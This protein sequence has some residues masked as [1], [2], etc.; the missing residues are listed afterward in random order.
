MVK[1]TGVLISNLGTPESPEPKDVASYLSEFLM[2]PYVIQTPGWIRFFLVRGLIVPF[3]KKASSEKYKKIWTEKGSP[4][5][6]ETK[7]F[8]KALQ[9]ALGEK[10]LVRFAMRYGQPGFSRAKDELKDCE[11]VIYFPQYPQYAQSTV[12]TSLQHFYRFFSKESP[13]IAPY[14]RN[15][16]FIEAYSF[17]LKDFLKKTDFDYLLMSFHGLPLSHIKR[18]DP[19]KSHCLPPS[20]DHI[21]SHLNKNTTKS[22]CLP[23]SGDCCSVIPEEL[24]KTCYRAQCFASARLIARA[25]ALSEK[26]YGVSFQSRLGPNR[27]IGPST[28]ESYGRLLKLGVRRLAVVCPGF[29]VDGLE[30]LEEIAL[31]GKKSFLRQG[32][33]SFHFIPC[34]N[35]SP[36]WVQAAV[37]MIKDCS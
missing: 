35:D 23:P 28:E 33:D 11:R 24:L 27:W 1:K 17:F 25:L 6:L 12:E 4:L 16:G 13:V 37:K 15:P 26:Q 9:K 18:T 14:Y 7:E 36:Y 2:D 22:H 31:E 29:S 19:T 32:G 5:R 30:T 3:R 20:G 21:S 8:T 10:Y 34:L